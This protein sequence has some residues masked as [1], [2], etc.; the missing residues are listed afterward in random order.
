MMSTFGCNDFLGN[1][2]CCPMCH[3]DSEQFGIEMI[4]LEHEGERVAWVCCDVANWLDDTG[5][6]G[7]LGLD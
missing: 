6:H 5:L 7:W 1:P 2:G 3:E 4:E